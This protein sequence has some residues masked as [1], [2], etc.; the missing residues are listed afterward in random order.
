MT[1]A[2]A[3]FTNQQNRFGAFEIAVVGQGAGAAGGVRA[4]KAPISI[5]GNWMLRQLLASTSIL[6]IPMPAMRPL[7]SGLTGG[8]SAID[9]LTTKGQGTAGADLLNVSGLHV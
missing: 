6:W 9:Y 7:E 8:L 4:A 5:L 3:G 1:L 2:D